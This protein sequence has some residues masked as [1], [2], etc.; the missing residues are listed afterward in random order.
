MTQPD[1]Y[2]TG[3][4]ALSELSPRL[5]QFDSLAASLF[6]GYDTIHDTPWIEHEQ[7][8]HSIMSDGLKVWCLKQWPNVRASA[9][10]HLAQAKRRVMS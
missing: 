10:H 7:P 3:R 5:E 9:A 2:D 1:Q 4:V 6:S 8:K